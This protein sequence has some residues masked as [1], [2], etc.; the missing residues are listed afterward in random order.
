LISRTKPISLPIGNLTFSIGF[1]TILFPIERP[2]LFTRLE[3]VEKSRIGYDVQSNWIVGWPPLDLPGVN[4]TVTYPSDGVRF[5]YECNWEAPRVGFS[6]GIIR[7]LNTTGHEW[8]L[9]ART[10]DDNPSLAPPTA[11]GP[12]ITSRLYTASLFYIHQCSCL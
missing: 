6:G 11:G 1:D 5:Q 10:G 4:G 9:W 8:L 12:S 3:Q 2:A 7:S